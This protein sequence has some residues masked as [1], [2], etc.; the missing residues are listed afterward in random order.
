MYLKSGSSADLSDLSP[1]SRPV[2]I[3]TFSLAI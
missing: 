2:D 1:V 3:L